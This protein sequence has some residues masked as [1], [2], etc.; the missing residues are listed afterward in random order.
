LL[1]GILIAEAEGRWLIRFS[2]ATSGRLAETTEKTTLI[3]F[4]HLRWDFV[5]QRPQ[6]LMSRFA[7]SMPVL[8]WEEP[9]RSADAAVPELRSVICPAT[10]VVVL[11]PC[12]PAA[13]AEDA[14][15]DAVQALLTARMADVPQPVV[16]WYYTPMMLPVSQGIPAACVVY[17]CMDE[18]TGFKN[19]PAGLL[20][21][22]AQLL[23]Q[24]DL[25]FTG[26]R[27]LF[28]AKR[29]LHPSVHL[30]PSS[31]DV[32]HFATARA[33]GPEPDDQRRIP[34]TPAWAIAA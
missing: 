9:M 32:P 17:D 28:E 33:A 12:C 29:N 5:F 14:V 4:S 30:F 31:V 22:E 25:V 6:H 21:L 15:D 11:T 26:G 10:G 24:A 8:F 13:F 23:D 27:S 1:T 19:A 3:C 34:G 7:R 2:E 16:R 20:E 18:L